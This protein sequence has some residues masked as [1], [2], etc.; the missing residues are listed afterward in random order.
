MAKDC[1]K[2]GLN[3]EISPNLV[4][5]LPSNTYNDTTVV[6]KTKEYVDGCENR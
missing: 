5:P 4:T 3:G 1:L 6:E 2:L